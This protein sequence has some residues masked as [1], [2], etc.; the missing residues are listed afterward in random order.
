VARD[1][2]L[3]RLGSGAVQATGLRDRKA[4]RAF[5]E[6]RKSKSLYAPQWLHG[7]ASA[8][9]IWF[10]EGKKLGF[11]TSVTAHKKSSEWRKHAAKVDRVFFVH[12]PKAAAFD[13]KSYEY[14]E[15][16]KGER[17][18]KWARTESKRTLGDMKQCQTY[19]SNEAKAIKVYSADSASP[20]GAIKADGLVYSIRKGQLE[21][22]NH[23]AGVLSR[24]TVESFQSP[25][26]QWE[27]VLDIDALNKKEGKKWSLSGTFPGYF[28]VKDS[29]G[30]MCMLSMS[31]GG[32]DS[33][34]VREYNLDKREFVHNGFEAPQDPRLTMMNVLDRDTVVIGSD[35]TGDK[36]T[37][38]DMGYPRITKLWKR[39]TPYAEAELFHECPKSDAYCWPIIWRLAN[40]VKLPG[41]QR[42][43]TNGQKQKWV[44]ADKE[45]KAMELPLP[46]FFDHKGN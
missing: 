29:R 46:D 44:V 31:D 16:V 6:G 39:G 9:P 8:S 4:I 42:A 35:W 40:D 21:S 12:E 37:L 3:A 2:V 41:V 36:K 20:S 28:I 27:E 19:A 22:G 32:S 18:L 1:S 23:P 11:K 13:M 7:K 5:L 10:E 24:C 30:T 25:S 38:T 26:P 15:E 14:L 33:T 34:Y 17:A 43:I 45:G